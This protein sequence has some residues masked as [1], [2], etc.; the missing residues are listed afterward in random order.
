MPQIAQLL[1]TYASQIFWLLLTFGIIYFGIAKTMLP[2]I[3]ANIE[4]RE[5]KIANDLAAAEKARVAA[6]ELEG[7]GDKALDE[8]RSEAQAEAGKAKAKAAADA[9]K[10]MAKAEL[11]ID[12]KLAAADAELNMARDKAMAKIEKVAAEAASDIAQKVAG[13]NVTAAQADNAV[14]T[15]MA[16]G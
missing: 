6:E 10:R 15:V 14:K 2:K 7:D 8:A 11:E 5:L 4:S 1:E 13:V 9:E 3:T 12:E 16:N